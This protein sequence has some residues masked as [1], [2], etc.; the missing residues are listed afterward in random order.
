MADFGAWRW[1]DRLNLTPR[2]VGATGLVA[3]LDSGLSRSH[4]ALRCAKISAARSFV[5][6]I[7]TV[8]DVGH[9]SAC[10]GV[11]VAEAGHGGPEGLLAGAEIVIGQVIGS[12]G[13]G[14]VEVLNEGLRWAGDCGAK[15]IALPLGFLSPDDALEKT[16][17]DLLRRDVVLVAAAGN[18]YAGQV[19]PMY[20]AACPGVVCVGV[21][22]YAPEYASWAR[23]PDM[24]VPTDG[25]PVVD[26]QG[27]WRLA[28]GTSVAAVIAA[29][30]IA[31]AAH[32]TPS[33]RSSG[34]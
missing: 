5:G 13:V 29:G 27:G 20:P 14:T 18:P 11:L 7:P 23:P 8:D 21:A 17:S 12:D 9:G 32:P 24:L 15:V 10:A 2:A 31:S 3:L 33:T 34:T 6:G 28:R 1:A 30:L 25:V 22:A 26:V 16:I 19:G 4:P